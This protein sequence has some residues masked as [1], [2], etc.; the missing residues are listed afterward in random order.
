MR[1]LLTSH[2]G[3]GHLNPLVPIGRAL[4][5]RGHEVG[6]AT[7]ASF[8]RIVESFG[9]RAFPAGVDWEESDIARSFP[10]AATMS[11]EALD[12]LIIERIMWD[13]AIT[14]MVP[15]IIGI[16]RSW[17][18]D[19]ILRENTEAAGCIAAEVMGI[20]HA[21]LT[22]LGFHLSASD[23]GEIA[24]TKI[25]E[26]RAAYGLTPDPDLDMLYRH[27][28]LVTLPRRWFADSSRLPPTAEWLRPSV[29]APGGRE[30]APLWLTQLPR[31]PTVWA[32]LG[33]VYHRV[34]ERLLRTVNEALGGEALNVILS[35]GTG[36]DLAT[37][38]TPA[39]NVRV[40]GFIRQSVLMPYCDLVITHGGPS[41]VMTAISYGVPLV[42]IPLGADQPHNAQRVAALGF[43][44]IVL[45]NAPRASYAGPCA[46]P[47][48]VKADE[49][50][51]AV[52]S[53]LTD[54]SFRGRAEAERAE[55]DRMPGADRGAEIL[56][57]LAAGRLGH[58]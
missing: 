38:G 47:A 57:Q 43:G 10:E 5:V 18:P 27:L 56:E 32:S 21:A 22:I 39:P 11:T 35:T 40:E 17:G 24:K 12:Q 19:V 37:L 52:W 13:A 53:V 16:C 8:C 34:G 6:V 3:F 28:L 29:L 31:R 20:P 42:V 46:D 33:T 1:V 49:V 50:R 7:P 23:L 2:P 51:K 48:A 36:N 58:V 30:T 55:F 41:T 15:D 25:H 4:Q 45:G 44:V 26:L 9:F 54:T 14:S